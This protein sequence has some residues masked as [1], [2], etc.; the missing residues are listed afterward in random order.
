MSIRVKKCFKNVSNVQIPDEIAESLAL[1]NK[2]GI[3]YNS[4]KIPVNNIVAI[5]ENCIKNIDH[6]DDKLKIR[7]TVTDIISNHNRNNKFKNNNKIADTVVN[8]QKIP[9]DLIFVKAD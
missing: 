5:I 9:K 1:G 6:D 8:F 7:R 4:N 2:F 3:P